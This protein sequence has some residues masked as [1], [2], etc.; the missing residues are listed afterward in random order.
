MNKMSENFFYSWEALEGK[1]IIVGWMVD[2]VVWKS[3]ILAHCYFFVILVLV[4]VLGI[5][6][7]ISSSY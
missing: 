2:V 4:P 5:K 7:L 1:K 3:L 6:G